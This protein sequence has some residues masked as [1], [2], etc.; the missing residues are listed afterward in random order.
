MTYPVGATPVHL[1]LFLA[2]LVT[3]LIGGLAFA[4]LYH[5]LHDLSYRGLVESL[6][7]ISCR[8]IFAALLAT[9]LSYILLFAN[10]FSA[11]YYAR[12]TPPLGSTLLASF[13]G[14]ALGNFIGLGPHCV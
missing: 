3:S 5:V 6:A 9:M 4:A 7:S 14:Y 13:C 1:R 11:L 2:I 10:D 8:A 12:A